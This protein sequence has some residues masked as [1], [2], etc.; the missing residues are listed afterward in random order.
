MSFEKE[1]EILKKFNGAN[2]HR[3]IVSL[4]ATY[5]HRKKYHFIFDRAQSDLG[6]FWADYEKPPR[7]SRGDMVWIADQC[8]GITEGLS[9]IHRHIIIKKWEDNSTADRADKRIRKGGVTF[10]ESTGRAPHSLITIENEEIVPVSIEPYRALSSDDEMSDHMETKYGRHGDIN[11][12]NILWF[13]DDP[14]ELGETLEVLGETLGTLRGTLKIADFGAA[15]M[16]SLRSRSGRRDVANTMTYRLPECDLANRTIRQSFDIWC[17]GCVFLEFVTWTL[18]GAGL[19]RSFARKRLS[20][21]RAYG[22]KKTDTYFELVYDKSTGMMEA[23][24][25]HS[26]LEVCLPHHCGAF[27]ILTKDF[28]SSKRCT[29]T[30]D[31]RCSSTTC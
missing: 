17:L 18:G 7:L 19:F 11:P 8:F 3:H 29:I 31:A 28:S 22:N 10:V 2:S 15:E 14:E 5:S 23:N 1:R 20:R 12:Q 24:I 4:L 30:L 13:R 9:K 21:D 26:V 25:K 27:S 16:N 6:R